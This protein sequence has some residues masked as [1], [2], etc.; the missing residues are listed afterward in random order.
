MKCTVIFDITPPGVRSIGAPNCK[1]G[2]GVAEFK[3]PMGISF[4]KSGNMFVADT[5]N[6][7]VQCL[8]KTGQFSHIIGAGKQGSGKGELNNPTDTAVDSQGFLYVVD[9]G[10]S[11]ISVFTTQVTELL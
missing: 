5:E 2:C 11:R 7:R 6:N 4:D 9:S 10:N 3:K 8:K 1:A